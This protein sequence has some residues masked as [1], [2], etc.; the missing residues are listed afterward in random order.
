MF[1][2]ED[3][4]R[5]FHDYIEVIRA[6]E[7]VYRNRPIAYYQDVRDVQHMAEEPELRQYYDLLFDFVRGRRD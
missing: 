5:R 2:K 1:T 7:E 4:R 3:H 6:N